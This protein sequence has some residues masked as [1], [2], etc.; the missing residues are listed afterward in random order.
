MFGVV[1]CKVVYGDLNS[2]EVR[3]EK[4]NRLVK[5][6]G[7]DGVQYLWDNDE[8]LARICVREKPSPENLSS[9]IFKCWRKAQAD[10]MP[11]SAEVL[12]ALY[13]FVA[14]HE[15]NSLMTM[16]LEFRMFE[17]KE[18]VYKAVGII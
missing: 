13:F 7:E 3:E 14:S 2:G 15:D 6:N 18:E 16:N 5:N 8:Q 4:L 11:L 17:T 1:S 12:K 10:N 9:I